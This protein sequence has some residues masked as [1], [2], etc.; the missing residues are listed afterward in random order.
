MSSPINQFPVQ[1]AVATAHE[2]R[3]DRGANN[4]RLPCA[5]APL[6]G[7]SAPIA[8]HTPEAHETSNPP[9]DGEGV[10]KVVRGGQLPG[11]LPDGFT[12]DSL[13]TVEQFAIWRQK[14]VD[15]VRRELPVTKGVIGSSMKDRRIHP[16]T[17]LERSV[18]GWR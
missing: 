18:K 6:A 13:L 3:R 15:R 9:R 14:S 12:L 7:F 17:Y 4:N 1:E 11:C 10:P 2:P 16:R 8:A 5:E